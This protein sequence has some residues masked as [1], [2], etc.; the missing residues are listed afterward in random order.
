MKSHNQNYPYQYHNG[1]IWPFVG[2]FWICAL[3][4]T[5]QSALAREE[6]GKLA[7]A[8]QK[9]NWQFNEWFHGKTGKPMGMPGQSWN[10]GAFLLAYYCLKDKGMF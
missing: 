1:G 4:K 8:N 3:E 2:G 5:G 6:L 9:N 10:A 7:Q